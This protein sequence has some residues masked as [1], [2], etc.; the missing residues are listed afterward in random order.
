M[1]FQKNKIQIEYLG[2][3]KNDTIYKNNITLKFNLINITSDTLHISNEH[4]NIKCRNNKKVLKDYPLVPVGGQIIVIPQ[5][6]SK[7]ER[8]E[9]KTKNTLKKNFAKKVL[10]YNMK[11]NNNIFDK[12]Y[13]INI[14]ENETIILL[15]HEKYNYYSFIN[16]KKFNTQTKVILEYNPTK[17]FTSFHTNNNKIIPIYWQE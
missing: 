6:M 15:P 10:N 8:E 13:A 11:I 3:E 16:N 1:N 12:L 7:A 4:F 5:Q 17:T 14:I 2:Y 9:Q